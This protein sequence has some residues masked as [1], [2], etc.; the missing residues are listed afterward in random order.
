MMRIDLQLN[1]ATVK[2]IIP[3]KMFFVLE[4][5]GDK[6]WPN[7]EKSPGA[8][9]LGDIFLY[10]ETTKSERLGEVNG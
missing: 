2:Q 8:V 10:M 6:V 5:I 3:R 4:I 9:F 7:I 1:F